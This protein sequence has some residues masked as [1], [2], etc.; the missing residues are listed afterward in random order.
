[1]RTPKIGAM[2]GSAFLPDIQMATD[3]FLDHPLS[4][5][6]DGRI[7]YDKNNDYS[8]TGMKGGKWN[9]T[10]TEY[11]KF[12]DLLHDYLFVK[13]YRPL[14]LVEKRQSDGR[15]PLLIDLDFKFPENKTLT[16]SFNKAHMLVFI[17]DVMAKLAHFFDLSEKKFV[18]FFVTLRPNAYIAKKENGAPGKEVKDGIHIESPDIV[19]TSDQQKVL[20]LALVQDGAVS[21]AFK[22]I[23]YQHDLKDAKIFDESLAQ[24]N[25]WFFY[26]ESKHDVPPYQLEHVFKYVVKSGKWTE[27]HKENYAPNILLEILSIRYN[28]KEPVKVKDDASAEFE[29]LFAK[30]GQPAAARAAVEEVPEDVGAWSNV[31]MA[32]HPESEI[33]MAKRLVL[34]CLSAERADD[35][36]TWIR[37]GWCIRNLDPSEDGFNLW[38]DFSR[39][40]AKFS[41][42]D[43]GNRRRDWFRGAM[44]SV[45]DH[46]ALQ[47]GSLCRW[48]QEDNIEQYKAI[49]A[50]DNL[51]YIKKVAIAFKGGTHHHCAELMRKVFGSIYRCSVE[52]KSYEWFRYVGNIWEPLPQGIALKE[53]MSNEI[54]QL[55]SQAKESYKIKMMN[56]KQLDDKQFTEHMNKFLEMEKNLYN[57]NFKDAVLKE[58]VQAFYEENFSQKM[59][60]N[61]FTV[62]CANGILHLHD[63]IYDASGRNVTGYRVSLKPGTPHDYVSFRAGH[64]PPE[65]DAIEYSEYDPLDPDQIEL[66][67]FFSKIFPDEDVRHY[68]LVLAASC[69]EGQNREQCYYI[70]TGIGGNGKT[71]F[72]DLMRFTLGEY[73]TTLSTTALTRK[74]PDSGAANPDIISIKNKRFIIMQEP[75][76]REQLNTAR[77]K[78]FSGEDIVEARGL[79]K[80]QERF[81]IT[82][83]FFMSCNRLPPITSM[84]EGTWRRIRVIPFKSKFVAVG[85]PEIDPA[86][87]IYPRDGFLEE[88]MKRW[89]KPFFS[90]L[91]HYYKTYYMT[92]GIKS[93]PKEVKRF[94][95]EYKQ[96]HDSFAKFRQALLRDVGRAAA[97]LREQLVDEVTDFKLIKRAY[98]MWSGDAGG[99]KQLS[100]NEL[101]IRCQEAFG[102]PADGKSF[103]GV[104]LFA[105]EDEAEA[106]DRGESGF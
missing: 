12:L 22:E 8:M 29:T 71:K 30:A 98:R 50:D 61:A 51:N 89:R 84:D 26:G 79:F 106:F 48:A 55:V 35:Y 65:M 47:F 37:V 103:K 64:L 92:D 81:K 80:D 96:A 59:N 85:S 104:K 13:K 4:K 58:C 38:M 1:M 78:Q 76:E 97:H 94:S 105:N 72:V 18:R 83:K 41:E 25:G 74:R 39:K 91:V 11:P 62:G 42:T 86:N 69:L 102:T 100:E 20:R 10:D 82:G 56:N 63:P 75:D 73:V 21:K 87:N 90:L 9:I 67:D 57:A 33:E 14:N 5:F 15:T 16:H 24:K 36:N 32:V 70:M 49:V 101:K 53:K 88:K 52:H 99:A 34:E 28:L 7:V 54:A 40:S 43:V 60:M 93:V 68:V 6:L 23:G 2:E 17:Q 66:M 44:T 27:E 46:R 45:G 31:L 3:S 77:M 19:L 95:E